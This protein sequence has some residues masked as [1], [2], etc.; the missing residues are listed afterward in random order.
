M[1]VDAATWDDLLGGEEAAHVETLPAAESHTAPLP[2]NLD[3]GLREALPFPTLYVHQRE[4]F[5]VAARG[6]HLILATGTASGKSLGFN[7]PVL[8]RIAREPKSR[9]LYLYPTKALA[10]DQARALAPP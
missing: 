3:S 4:A 7:L 10:Q 9:A 8:D 5:D 2:G 6:E 1:A